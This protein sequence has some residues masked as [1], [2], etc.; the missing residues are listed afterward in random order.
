MRGHIQK[1]KPK[2]KKKK[3]K[4]ALQTLSNL[5]VTL[6]HI[7]TVSVL[8]WTISEYNSV[9]K[10][11]KSPCLGS[12][13]RLCINPL[14]I[15]SLNFSSALRRDRQFLHFIAVKNINQINR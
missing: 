14:I 6:S 1:K 10:S 2:L 7:V 3:K 4:K 13:S 12:D 11:L 15:L 8:A 5:S 9:L